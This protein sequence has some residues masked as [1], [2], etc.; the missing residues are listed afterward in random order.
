MSNKII[1]SLNELL[2]QLRKQEKSSMQH[3]SYEDAGFY[4]GISIGYGNAADMLEDWINEL[5]N[6]LTNNE[7]E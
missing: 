3:G 5:P 4:E 2:K 7:K 1:D 6:L